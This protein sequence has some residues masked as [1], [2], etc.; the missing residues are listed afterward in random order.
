M[1]VSEL[2][3]LQQAQGLLDGAAD[4]VVVDLHSTDLASRI[5]MEVRVR[6][7]V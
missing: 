1:A 4:L 5:C 2:E 3:S 7:D 6:K